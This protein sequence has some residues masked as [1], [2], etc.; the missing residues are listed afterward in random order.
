MARTIAIGVVVII[1]PIHA[2]ATTNA[3]VRMI[4]RRHR[5]VAPIGGAVVV[6]EDAVMAD[7]PEAP[8]LPLS[9]A[10]D[11]TAAATMK[12]SDGTTS[13][14]AMATAAVA[15]EEEEYDGC[16]SADPRR[17]L[18][19]ALL[20]LADRI[21]L[22]S[23]AVTTGSAAT[24]V[25]TGILPTAT[26]S[27]PAINVGALF[28]GWED[29]EGDDGSGVATYDDD[30]ADGVV[31]EYTHDFLEVALSQLWEGC[32]G[33]RTTMMAKTTKTSRDDEHEED[34]VPRSMFETLCKG[35]RWEMHR[36][37]VVVIVIVIRR[38]FSA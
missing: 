14:A 32:F 33:M 11:P 19:D 12:T 15:T 37:H 3:A 9:D 2:A 4:R 31:G 27:M 34:V 5:I 38:R 17:R 8:R 6:N 23:I 13:V 7:A 22:C 18:D 30:G 36:G 24:A 25:A 28:I 29:R 16:D 1:I 21:L 10:T 20:R 26:M 35:V